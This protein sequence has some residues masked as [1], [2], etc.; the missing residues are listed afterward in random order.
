M[1]FQK[2]WM[3]CVLIASERG[4]KIK[5]KRRGNLRATIFSTVELAA[6]GLIVV[7]PIAVELVTIELVTVELVTVELVTVEL[8]TGNRLSHRLIMQRTF[9]SIPSLNADESDAP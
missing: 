2:K 7:K 6:V 1:T 3:S 8:V 5:L 4:Q 9:Q